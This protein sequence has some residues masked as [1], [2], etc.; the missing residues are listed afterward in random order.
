V[1]IFKKRR[2]SGLEEGFE[3]RKMIIL[4]LKE[5]KFFSQVNHI[6]FK[7]SGKILLIIYKSDKIKK[8]LFD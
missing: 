2:F 8:K 6:Y 4:F 1:K 5:R 3:N 7:V